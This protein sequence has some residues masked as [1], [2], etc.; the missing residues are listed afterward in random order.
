VIGTSA[1]TGA[2]SNQAN[3]QYDTHDFFDALAAGNLPSVT[4]LKAPKFQN[5]HPGNSDPLDEQ[6]YVVSVISA[7]QDSPFWES[8]AVV[9]AYDDSDV[10]VFNNGALGFIEIEQKS[11][12]F[13]DFGTRFKNPNFA[14]MAEAVGVRGIRIEDPGDVESGIA[15]A[16]AHDG[17]VLVDAVVSRMVLLVR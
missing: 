12:G 3:H 2:G 15:Q 4:F 8:T 11:S 1:D 9:I 5:A 17:P 14:A 13:L 10:V 16:L 6:V 7:L